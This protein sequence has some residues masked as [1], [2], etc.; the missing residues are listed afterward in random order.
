LNLDS[1]DSKEI[2]MQNTKR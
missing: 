1:R 2:V